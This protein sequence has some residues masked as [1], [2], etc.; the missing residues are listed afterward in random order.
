MEVIL[1]IIIVALAGIPSSAV[2]FVVFVPVSF[3]FL[4]LLCCG[5]AELPSTLSKALDSDFG[6]F[7]TDCASLL[8]PNPSP[9]N[10]ADNGI[11]KL[12]PAMLP[13][14]LNQLR[15]N[16]CFNKRVLHTASQS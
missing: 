14:L 1:E 2:L 16:Q 12:S 3:T 4:L 13:L 10:I 11:F 7:L 5:I 8:Q 9:Q 15:F 6:T